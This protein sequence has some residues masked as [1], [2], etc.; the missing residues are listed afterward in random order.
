MRRPNDGGPAFPRA[1]FDSYVEPQPAVDEC[2]MSLRQWYAGKFAAAL[3]G[4]E[5]Y[6]RDLTAKYNLKSE[7]EAF[8]I[9]ARLALNAADIL[10]AESEKQE[11]DTPQPQG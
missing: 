1:A 4:S 11:D 3:L 5:N 8:L 6:V 9:T 2:G 10:I 7:E